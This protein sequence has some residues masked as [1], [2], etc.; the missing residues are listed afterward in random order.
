MSTSPF[1]PEVFTPALNHRVKRRHEPLDVEP[2]AEAGVGQTSL[3]LQA[4]GPYTRWLFAVFFL[5]LT[6]LSARLLYL[7]GWRG[8]WYRDRA[9]QNRIR[10]VRVP[11]PRGLIVDRNNQPLVMNVANFVLTITPA[12]LPPKGSERTRVVESVAL[13]TDVTTAD[14]QARLADR[15]I[16]RTDPVT[17][18]EDTNYDRAMSWMLASNDLPGVS[19]A[20]VPTRSYLDG[21]ASAPVLGYVGR[22]SPEDLAR[23]SDLTSLSLTGKTGLEKLYDRSLTGLDGQREIERDAYNRSQRVLTDVAPTPGQTLRL[24]IDRNLQN[25]LYAELSRAVTEHHSSGGAAVALD[26]RNGGVLALASAPSYDNNWFIDASHRNDVER[27][28][29]DARTPLL[30]RAISGQYPSGSIIKPVIAVGALAERIITPSTTILSTGG[31]TVGRNNFPD[32][33]AGGHGLTNLAKAIAESVNTY[34]YAIGGGYEQQP[35]L[36]V[37]RI[38]K[39]LQLFGWGRT[40]GIDLPGEATGFLPT[41]DWR[42]KQ[43]LSPWR[44]GDTYHL[45][46]GQGDLKVTPLQI[47]LSAA[48]I[49]NGGTIYEPHLVGAVLDADGR[50][51]RRTEPRIVRSRVVESNAVKAVQ[52]GMRQG[53]L[54]GSSRALQDLTVPAAAKTGTAQFGREGKT[55]AWFEAYAPYDRPTIVLA[56]IVEGAGEGHAAALPVAHRV[57]AWYFSRSTSAPSSD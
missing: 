12:D 53:V 11:A 48:A 15:R 24:T 22:V 2:A 33:K 56:V 20:T 23:Q 7:Q 37:D 36:G 35:G 21:P 30:N 52:T 55:H 32:W 18:A 41:K 40:S 4:A 51:I 54:D 38:V 19:V 45:S 10:T 31:F 57:L 27:L 49:A 16:R 25:K 14:V 46:I 34:F 8:A 42:E 5:V 47:A 29:T 39:Y 44:L 50:T 17:I 6:L 13:M 26:P 28:L 9:E 3:T 43:R 1:D